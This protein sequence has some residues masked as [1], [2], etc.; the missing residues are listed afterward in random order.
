MKNEKRIVTALLLLG[1]LASACSAFDAP[2]PRPKCE[3]GRQYEYCDEGNWWGT[4]GV[5]SGSGGA[6]CSAIYQPDSSAFPRPSTAHE[7]LYAWS[8]EA[9]LEAASTSD[10]FTLGR[11]EFSDRELAALDARGLGKV[12]AH[13]SSSLTSNIIYNQQSF[14]H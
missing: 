1:T 9:Q 14:T 12:T 7:R 4:G 3:Y 6:A 13:F 2:E 11:D 8:A 5:V 10:D